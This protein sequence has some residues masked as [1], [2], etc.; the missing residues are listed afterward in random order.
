MSQIPAPTDAKCESLVFFKS[1]KIYRVHLSKEC[2][3]NLLLSLGMYIAKRR[4]ATNKYRWNKHTS[5]VWH[6][7]EKHRWLIPQ[8]RSGQPNHWKSRW[9]HPERNQES[10]GPLT[11]NLNTSLSFTLTSSPDDA[12]CWW[13]FRCD[14]PTPKHVWHEGYQKRSQ[15]P[16]DTSA[17][18][19]HTSFW[20]VKLAHSLVFK[21]YWNS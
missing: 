6:W 8:S 4:S 14:P 15:L 18:K 11:G 19:T 16:E 12:I 9:P 5:D 21:I 2:I 7:K 1:R 10:E 20:L 3:T 13:N 17:H